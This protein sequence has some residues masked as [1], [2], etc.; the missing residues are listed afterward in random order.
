MK[1]VKMYRNHLDQWMDTTLTVLLK[2]GG[3]TLN[4]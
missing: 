2:G 1:L 4:T 3:A